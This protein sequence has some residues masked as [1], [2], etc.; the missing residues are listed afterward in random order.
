[1]L[2]QASEYALRAVV[3][4][5]M[6]ETNEPASASDISAMTKVPVPYLQ[7]VLRL[8]T[9]AGILTAQRGVGG[10]FQL[11]KSADQIAVL[12]VLK[13]CDS[14][15]QRI[16]RCPLGIKGHS[17]LCPLHQLLD[18]QVAGVEK[19]FANTTIRDILESKSDVKPLCGPQG[20][21]EL[22]LQLGSS[23]PSLP[24]SD[25]KPKA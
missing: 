3:F 22:G 25:S 23:K 12:D 11:A 7:K 20:F 1:M 15:P 9:R 17:K 6:A 14:Q 19:V 21:V 24:E 8:L 16:E 18:Q 2:N 10:G 13:A 4:L 5:C